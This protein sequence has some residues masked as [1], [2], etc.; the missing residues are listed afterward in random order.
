MKSIPTQRSSIFQAVGLLIFLL[1]IQPAFALTTLT[2]TSSSDN[3]PGG[4]GEVGDFRYA[5]NVMN[6]NL[7]VIP[8]DYAIV[9]A[10]PMTIQLN[11]ILP[12][13]N[14]SANPVNITIGNPSPSS[15]V[16]IDG[17]GGTYSGFFIPTGNVKLQNMVLQN[18]TAKGGNGGNGISGGGGGMGAGGAIYAPQSFLNGSNPSVTLLNVSIKNASAIGGNG[19]SY[20][21]GTLTG[22]EGGGGGGGFSGNGGSISTIGSTGG[23]GG[24]GFGGDGGAVS[25][26][27][28]DVHGG[29]GGGGGGLGSRATLGLLFNLGN[30]G[31]DQ[32]PGL[33]GN[34]FGLSI[35]AGFG[36]AGH[37]G[38]SRAGGGG[39]GAPSSEFG[40]PGGGG[41]GSSG[42][43]G[44]TAQGSIAARAL[45]TPS[46]GNGGDGAG[47][48]GSGIVVTAVTN[49]VD[50]Q[51][52]NGGYGGGGGGGAGS[53]AYDIDYSQKGGSGGIGGGGG[54]GGT[55]WSAMTPSGGGN[56][57]GGGGGA[58]GGPSNGEASAGGADIGRLGG[59]SGGVGMNSGT[60]G[61]GGGGGGSGLGGAIFIDSNLN[62]T[63]Q[64]I[65]GVPTTF[66]TSNNSTQAGIRG[67][68]A[69]GGA[70]DGTDGSALGESIFLRSTASLTFL[71]HDAADLLTLGEQV[72][73]VDDTSFGAGGTSIFVRGNGRVIYNGNSTYEGSI[74]VEN[75]DFKVNGEINQAPV[76]VMRNSSFSDQKS[77]LSGTGRLTGTV[78]TNAGVIYPDPGATL[79]LGSLVLASSEQSA[80]RTTINTG[81]A[82]LISV[83]GL[84]SLAGTLEVNLDP[85]ANRAGSYTILSSAGIAG[86][87]DS[88]TFTG[89]TPARYSLSYLPMGAPTFVQLD[90]LDPI[91]IPPPIPTPV[92]TIAP[93]PTLEGWAVMMLSGLIG[94][95]WV[96][97]RRP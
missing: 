29:G 95:V 17:N 52:G 12:L 65:P 41:G 82:S 42:S 84:A 28:N 69:S 3:N 44:I 26:S 61:G 18:L 19:G 39:G 59:G 53:G 71:A 22:H 85:A 77:T 21:G 63:V 30:G 51:G 8:D 49:D 93:V 14:N 9:F 56:S 50:G 24:G 68:G 33:D 48:G 4:Q 13:I 37:N 97:R 2:V 60:F 23:G 58:G 80:V 57:L 90:I 87:F 54:G 6:S 1:T 32:T 66:D 40:A 55:N 38:G 16:T 43:N 15:T 11:G 78:F 94:L 45:A 36:G 83:I 7:N 34:G 46:A 96:Q 75:A 91:P 88:V 35:T 20:A 62:F 31:S 92:V 89:A 76:F 25:L 70:T 73:F 79:T 86:A 81:G 74:L 10:S 5:L 27:T 47:G 64:A 67:T 72:A